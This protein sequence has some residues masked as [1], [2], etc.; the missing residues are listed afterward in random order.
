MVLEVPG[1]GLLLESSAKM[2]DVLPMQAF[3]CTLSDSIIE[4][5]IE[6]AQNGQ[7]ISLSL[8]DNPVSAS[9]RGQIHLTL[10]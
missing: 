6:A 4:S 8:G 1:A 10:H 3:A 2:E 5:M 7:G 9:L